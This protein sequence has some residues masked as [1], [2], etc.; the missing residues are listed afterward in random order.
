M[1]IIPLKYE[2]QIEINEAK[3]GALRMDSLQTAVEFGKVVAV[4]YGVDEFDLK[5]KVG[6][7]V[8]FKAWSCDIITHEGKKYYFINMNT[9]GIKAI[10]K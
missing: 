4:G 2:V 5:L 1:K 6:D 3:A 9:G 8:M 7:N 10:I